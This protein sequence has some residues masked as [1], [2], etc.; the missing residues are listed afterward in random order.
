MEQKTRDNF[1]LVAAA[2]LLLLMPGTA[3]AACSTPTANE[4][5]IIYNSTYH[6][7]QF[8]NGSD[9][10][11]AGGGGGSGSETD[12]QVGDV[13]ISAKWCRSDGDSVECDQD[14]PS[15]GGGNNFAFQV[16]RTTAA[17]HS[18]MSKVNFDDED[19]PA[20]VFNITTD[21]YLPTQAGYYFISFNGASSS[22][23]E[24]QNLWI[25]IRKNGTNVNGA[26]NAADASAN[27][28]SATITLVEYLNGTTDYIEF[29]AEETCASFDAWTLTANGFKVSD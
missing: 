29:F 10:V 28:A 2:A 18:S 6:V 22:C 11:N 15:G 21:R 19:D 1:W 12:P 9:W 26:W 23:G 24:G 4:G 5:A 13:S 17:N 14:A 27:V 16:N 7:L 3:H 8:C 20:S 25:V